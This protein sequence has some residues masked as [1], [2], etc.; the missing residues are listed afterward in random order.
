MI[1]RHPSALYAHGCYVTS[2]SKNS[3]KSSRL[4]NC[5]LLRPAFT[6]SLH[7]FVHVF[8]VLQS[9]TARSVL[10]L[11]KLRLTLSNTCKCTSCSLRA[12]SLVGRVSWAKELARR[13]GRGKLFLASFFSPVLGS[14]SP[15][16]TSEPAR[17][18]HKLIYT[19]SS[20]ERFI[21]RV[22]PAKINSCKFCLSK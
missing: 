14:L 8:S 11:S 17:R 5:L 10:F 7:V 22:I 19:G 13:M 3:K 1:E 4:T 12:G 15:T 16:Q 20:R 9:K 6:F 21:L 18:L 2:M